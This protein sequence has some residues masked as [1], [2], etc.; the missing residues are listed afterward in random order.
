MPDVKVLIVEDDPFF[1]TALKDLFTLH[2]PYIHVCH[3]AESIRQARRFLRENEVD[4]VFLDIE[5]PDGK[6]FDL[7]ASMEEMHFEAIITTSHSI[8]AIDAI[9]HSALDYLLKPVA[10]PE[11]E[12]ALAKFMK[13][14]QAGRTD[15]R[16][17][18]EEKP[19]FKKLP[20]P[21][22]DGFVF[23]NIDEIIHAEA[24]RAYAVFS[25][26]GGNKI[27]VSKPLGEF[28]ARLI[29]HNF[30]RVHKSHI[31]NLHEVTKYVRGEGGYVVMSNDG[32]VPVS[33]LRKDDFLKIIA[34]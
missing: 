32:I 24:D 19:V 31:I 26:K 23:V 3:I 27:M 13:R 6:G 34:R 18:P 29:K 21:T 16:K 28:E 33:R 10:Y 14:F 25:M 22:S 15:E 8:Y 17:M 4:L 30:F 9:R 12:A 20:L 11:M 7:L 5:L 1:C 2:F